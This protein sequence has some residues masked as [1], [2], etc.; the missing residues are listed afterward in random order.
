MWLD[1]FYLIVSIAVM[2][3]G[4]DLALESSEEVGKALGLSP[5]LV[6]LILVAFGTSLPEFCVSHISAFNNQSEMAVGNVIGSNIA[7]MCLVLGLSGLLTKIQVS[8]KAMKMHF[9]L[10]FVII[11]TLVFVFQGRQYYLA[12]SLL[13][14]TYF[15]YFVFRSYVDMKKSET[16]SLT[17]KIE[18]MDLKKEQDAEIDALT[19]KKDNRGEVRMLFIAF[20]LLCGFA[21]LYGSGEL[22]VYSGQ[23]L[24]IAMGVPK[25]VISLLLFAFGTSLPELVTCMLACI[26]KKDT[27]IITG[28]IIGSN[29]FNVTF[30]FGS[31]GVH[32]I[33]FTHNYTWEIICLLLATSILIY[34]NYKKRSFYRKSGALFLGMYLA[35][36]GYWILS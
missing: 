33:S 30:V 24:A 11:L 27:D 1:F 35:T 17:A 15:L 22:L 16:E 10:H 3:Y 8:G 28:N 21:L 4:A 34:L 2:T 32:G 5:L 23:N 26:K 25:S 18:S 29:I 6:G 14:A 20:R 13:F 12:W 31:L 7:N 19:E 9:I 36:V